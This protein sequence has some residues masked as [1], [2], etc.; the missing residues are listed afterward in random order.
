MRMPKLH[1]ALAGESVPA[2]LRNWKPLN[3][4]D[5][6]ALGIRLALLAASSIA[7]HP[8]DPCKKDPA[9]HHCVCDM[10]CARIISDTVLLDRLAFFCRLNPHRAFRG[11]A[12]S[13][14]TL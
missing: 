2:P 5:W 10:S 7:R 3:R 8:A 11:P 4:Q 6:R 13:A 1:A 9:D 14:E 12:L